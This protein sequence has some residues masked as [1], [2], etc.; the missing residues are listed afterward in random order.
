MHHYSTV[1]E[2]QSSVSL[3]CRLMRKLCPA[4]G[5]YLGKGD[6][7]ASHREQSNSERAEHLHTL[8]SHFWVIAKLASDEDFH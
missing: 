8:T 3:K 4:C 6:A 1:G 7:A 2:E 5:W